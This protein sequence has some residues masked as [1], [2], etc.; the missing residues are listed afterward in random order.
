MIRAIATV[1]S[2]DGSFDE[3]GMSHRTVIDRATVK[4]VRTQALRWAR[5]KRLRIEYHNETLLR[6]PFRKEFW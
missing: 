4:A 6:P 5:G 1:A 2:E 3:V